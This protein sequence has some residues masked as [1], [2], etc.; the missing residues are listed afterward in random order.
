M[1]C[2]FY[3]DLMFFFFQRWFY[4]LFLSIG[5]CFDVFL[6]WFP[7]S[8]LL[9]Y[10]LLPSTFNFVFDFCVSKLI[11]WSSF[12]LFYPLLWS[13]V[14]VVLY[15][16]FPIC[17]GMKQECQTNYHCNPKKSVC[18]GWSLTAL[19]VKLCSLEPNVMLWKINKPNPLH[20]APMALNCSNCPWK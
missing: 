19:N 20:R 8:T 5:W 10:L 12:F 13:T 1:F 7:F 17:H 3:S 18:F 16:P 4:V 15:C 9:L 6:S 2:K 11:S 14:F